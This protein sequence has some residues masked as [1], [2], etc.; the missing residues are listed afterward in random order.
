MDVF[1]SKRAS[2]EDARKPNDDRLSVRKW[3]TLRFPEMGRRSHVVEFVTKNRCFVGKDVYRTGTVRLTH[4][5]LDARHGGR[6]AVPPNLTGEFMDAVAADVKEDMLPPLNELKT[7][8][9]F[10]LF[11][12]LDVKCSA[13]C[14]ATAFSIG[15]TLARVAGKFLD[16]TDENVEWLRCLV[17]HR[18][19]VATQS[20]SSSS[21]SSSLSTDFP[22]PDQ[23]PPRVKRGIHVHFPSFRVNAEQALTMREA[24]VVELKQEHPGVDWIND[25]DNT[26]YVN[27]GTGLR[28]V[29]APKTISCPECC[30]STVSGKRVSSSQ[31][32][33]CEGRRKLE[34]GPETAYRLAACLKA[35]GTQ[36]ERLMQVLSQNAGQLV[37]AASIRCANQAMMSTWKRFPGCPSHSAIVYGAHAPKAGPKER[38]FAEDAVSMAKG[39]VR[40]PRTSVTQ[41]E[42]CD[43]LRDIFRK[44]FVHPFHGNVYANVDLHPI[45]YSTKDGGQYYCQFSGMGESFCFNVQRDHTSNRVYGIVT[46]THAYVRCHSQNGDVSSS[47]CGKACKDF[48]SDKKRIFPADRTILFGDDVPVNGVSIGGGNKRKLKEGGVVASNDAE[49]LKRRSELLFSDHSRDPTEAQ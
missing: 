36:D 33:L 34:A 5:F 30:S 11:L 46:R 6:I 24:F 19:D 39:S 35:D 38:K 21:T 12:D 25:F 13:D 41:S 4:T 40:W 10:N 16:D 18:P 9:V 43:R 14:S 17:L 32:C 8:V 2:E 7:E 3:S 27:E 26:P 22:P 20:S 45:K 47:V 29:G 1:F 49:Y 37:R 48:S 28:M 31:C 23:Q 44:R 15:P 42:Q